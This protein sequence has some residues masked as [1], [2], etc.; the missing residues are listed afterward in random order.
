MILNGNQ[1][2]RARKNIWKTNER[3]KIALLYDYFLHNERMEG[4]NKDKYN[5]KFNL[6]THRERIFFIMSRYFEKI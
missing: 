2:Q 4:R 1:K 3:R 6:K 5:I